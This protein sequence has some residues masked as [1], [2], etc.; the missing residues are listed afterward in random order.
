MN[1]EIFH[2]LSP[3]NFDHACF[4]LLEEIFLELVE[5]ARL[6]LIFALADVKGQRARE[7]GGGKMTPKYGKL[8]LFFL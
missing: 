1:L 6:S 3:I 4:K 5:I 7:R 2:R 8:T